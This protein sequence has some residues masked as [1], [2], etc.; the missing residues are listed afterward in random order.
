M[1]NPYRAE[2]TAVRLYLAGLRP[3][4]LAD[5]DAKDPRAF[6]RPRYTGWQNV[7]TSSEHFRRAHWDEQGWNLG[8]YLAASRL[9]VLDSDTEGAEAWAS[10]SLPETPW[11][12]RTAKGRHRFY[13]LTEE[14]GTPVDNKPVPGLDR[15]ARGYVLAPGSWHHEAG[16]PYVPEGDWSQPIQALP[17]YDPRWFPELRRIEQAKGAPQ[18]MLSGTGDAPARARLWLARVEPAIQGQNGSA[19]LTYAAVGLVRGFCLD[20]GTALYLLW[21]EYNPRCLPPWSLQEARRAVENAGRITPRHGR[22]DGWLL[23][24]KRTA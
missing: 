2:H 24:A 10:S 21:S 22:C 5:H 15:K 8:L 11:V 19:A 16:R 3:F 20:E 7:A 12:T 23:N 1:L 4:P 13:R 18:P 14:Q 17:V 9:V 6:K